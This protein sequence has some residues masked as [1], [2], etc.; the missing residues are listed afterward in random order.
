MVPVFDFK[1]WQASHI[2][3]E[4]ILYNSLAFCDALAV[5]CLSGLRYFR[6]FSMA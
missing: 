4:L 6:A 1:S 3:V 5:R 2:F